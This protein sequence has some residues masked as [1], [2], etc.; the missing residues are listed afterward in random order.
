MAVRRK[1]KR[2]ALWTK[3]DKVFQA[4]IAPPAPPRTIEDEIRDARSAWEHAQK[5]SYDRLPPWWSDRAER[6]R[7]FRAEHRQLFT[8]ETAA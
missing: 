2:P 5:C 4:S 6:E 7:R 1:R 8:V 3:A